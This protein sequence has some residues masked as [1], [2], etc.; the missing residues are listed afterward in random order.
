[1]EPR[2]ATARCNNAM[3]L[4]TAL[5]RATSTL[6]ARSSVL[7]R[8][9]T[10]VNCRGFFIERV[11]VI[12]PKKNPLTSD[13]DIKATPPQAMLAS[14]ALWVRR[15]ARHASARRFRLPQPPQ[16]HPTGLGLPKTVSIMPGL[17]SAEGSCA[18]AACV[19]AHLSS[20]C[21]NSWASSAGRFSHERGWQ[22]SWAAA[23]PT[24][25]EGPR[26]R[27]EAARG[28][29]SRRAPYCKAHDAFFPFQVYFIYSE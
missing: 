2:E 15:E 20:S 12:S 23:R 3:Q 22:C 8:P 28:N 21:D 27:R 18:K 5:E 10:A 16:C 6:P 9:S 17:H 25:R 7:A 11:C 14:C 13:V 19:V 24:R 29:A 26:T 4:H 1:M